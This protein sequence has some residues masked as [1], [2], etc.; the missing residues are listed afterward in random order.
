M[1]WEGRLSYQGLINEL[2]SVTLAVRAEHVLRADR[3]LAIKP[4]SCKSLSF[5]AQAAAEQWLCPTGSASPGENMETT[6]T[7]LTEPAVFTS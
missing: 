3:P 2:L 4:R 7:E 1:V 6:P 5:D